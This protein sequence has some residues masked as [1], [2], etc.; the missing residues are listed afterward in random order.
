MPRVP[1]NLDSALPYNIYRLALLLR[2][3][4]IRTLRD[5]DLT[6][7]Q[8]QILAALAGS[9]R[10]VSQMELSEITLKDRHSISRMLERM[11]ENGWIVRSDDPN[12]RRAFLVSASAKARA[13]HQK[14]YRLLMDAFQPVFQSISRNENEELMRISK[15]LI[16]ALSNETGE[17]T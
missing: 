8:W 1:Q 16:S 11:E 3:R 9:D 12:D 10:P 7:E 13:D 4:L 5:Y 2:R 14:L 6:P 17:L 15:K